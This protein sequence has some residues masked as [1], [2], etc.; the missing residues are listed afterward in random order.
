MDNFKFLFAQKLFRNA[1]IYD[2]TWASQVA[3]W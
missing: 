2:T 1:Y 3:Q